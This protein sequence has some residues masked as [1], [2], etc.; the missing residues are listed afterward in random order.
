V[1]SGQVLRPG[2][3]TPTLQLRSRLRLHED[4]RFSVGD[5][6]GA[7]KL[8]FPDADWRTVQLPHD[9]SIEGPFDEA[10]PAA[11]RG[12]FLPTG[13]GWY[14]KGFLPPALNERQKLLIEFEGVYRY[15]R[16][17]FNE[18][19]LGLQPAGFFP[20][21]YDLTSSIGRS[22]GNL[23]AVRVDN[24][25]QPNLRW[26]SGSGIYRHVWL[27]VAD[28]LRFDW[29]GVGV[30][31]KI[32]EPGL[33]QIRITATVRNDFPGAASTRVSA[34]VFD[35][36]G[37]VV[38]EAD[39]GQ[40]VSGQGTIDVVQTIFVAAPKLWSIEDPSLYSL[41]LTL[42]HD[43]QRVDDYVVEFGIRSVY[44]DKD[45]GFILNGRY[46]KLKGVSLHHDLGCLGAAVHE[47]AIARRLE[48][49]RALGCNAIRT[50]HNP[51]ARELL[52]LCDRMGFVV[53]DE[54]FDKWFGDFADPAPGDPR[55]LDGWQ[56]DLRSFIRRDRNHPCVAVWSIGN[57]AGRAG[58]TDH[59]Y[60]VTQLTEFVRKE[61][62]SRPVTVVLSP[63]DAGLDESVP[64]VNT[65]ARKVDVLGLNYQEAL[66]DRYRQDYQG[67]G[68]IAT[69]ALPY[70]QLSLD[71]FRPINP[72]WS[73]A[74]R[75]YV[76]GHFVWTGVDHM[77]ESTGWPSKGWPNGLFDR[78]VFPRVAS[79]FF[80]NVWGG[81]R[82]V[83]LSVVDAALDLD[84]GY[85]PWRWPMSAERW[86]F[87]GREGQPLQ[88]NTIA[89]CESVELILNGRSLGIG[90]PLTTANWMI[91]WAVLYEPGRLEAIG[92]NGDEI[93]A[94]DVLET[95]ASPAQIELRSKPERIAA[96]GLSISYIEARLLDEADRP[97]PDQDQEILFVVDGPARLIGVDNGDMRSQ[98]SFQG[99][100]RTTYQGRAIAV[101]QSTGKPGSISVYAVAGGLPVA[102]A[103]VLAEG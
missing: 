64:A 38:G 41:Q 17:W 59:E 4:W 92:R 103:G 80:L 93:V 40:V 44:F 36:E 54:A 19:Y 32:L 39:A 28:S 56:R 74:T 97:V 35:R 51:P 22:V 83:R 82:L 6:D 100:R 55:L 7:E 16:V 61:D 50:A 49:V 52:E 84:L 42:R 81:Q 68:Y 72:W 5:F 78:C 46:V 27:T 89:N 25:V 86:N 11:E 14:R 9:W 87:T 71:G 21:E 12:G 18:Q 30:T 99:P 57:E 101:I 88:V 3:T 26:Y 23:L 95:A 67:V 79:R 75:D 58:S 98:E 45:R 60:W 2:V 20:I 90:N 34:L 62:P 94:R 37:N 77:G 10:A 48:A 66:Y 96:D 63:Y 47:N 85:L 53:I 91:E 43:G 76:A 65:T 13:V 31:S 8:D 69:E 33:A 73:S 24:S 15:A 1:L 102:A 29:Q 70:F